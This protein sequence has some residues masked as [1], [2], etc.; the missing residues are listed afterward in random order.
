MDCLGNLHRCQAA[1]CKV[2]V[3]FLQDPALANNHPILKNPTKD[4]LNYY[5][6]HNC[7]LE[8]LNRENWRVIVE[9]ER[10]LFQM[11][12]NLWRMLITVNCQALTVDNKCGLH[13]TEEKPRTCR[14]FDENHQE[15]YYIPEKCVLNNTSKT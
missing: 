8:R 9:G 1:C 6:L 14:R 5:R 11:S 4:L 3:F 15:R 12:K 10:Q 2:L 13:G 7:K